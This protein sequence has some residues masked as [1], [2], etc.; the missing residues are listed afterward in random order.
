MTATHIHPSVDQGVAP[1][2]A[3]FAGGTQIFKT[4]DGFFGRDLWIGEMQLIEIDVIGLELAQAFV[5][6]T[7]QFSARA[8]TRRR[9]VFLSASLVNA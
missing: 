3:D 9:A 7:S 4:L 1:A 8:S 6:A 5:A 2:A